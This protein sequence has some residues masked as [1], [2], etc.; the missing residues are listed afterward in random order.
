M[1]NRLTEGSP[2][3]CFAPLGS[4]RIWGAP[5]LQIEGPAGAEEN[6]ESDAPTNKMHNSQKFQLDMAAIAISI[7]SSEILKLTVSILISLSSPLLPP[8]IDLAETN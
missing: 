5:H 4:K 3:F 6:L 2:I 1:S 7:R 8:G